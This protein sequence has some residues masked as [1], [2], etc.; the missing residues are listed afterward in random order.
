M[1]PLP[2]LR[3]T[4]WPKTYEITVDVDEEPREDAGATVFRRDGEVVAAVTVGAV[5]SWS[6]Q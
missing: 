1:S 3:D 6:R 4:S 2:Q 5:A